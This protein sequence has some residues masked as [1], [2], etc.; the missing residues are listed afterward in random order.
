MIEP[1]SSFENTQ[2]TRALTPFTKEYVFR[3]WAETR[4]SGWEGPSIEK[5]TKID[6]NKFSLVVEKLNV[7]A[8]KNYDVIS[9]VIIEVI[10]NDTKMLSKC[11]HLI[12]YRIPIYFDNLFLS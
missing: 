11:V 12:K 4:S 1:L 8:D 2:D 10:K 6:E 5:E 7:L 3:Y 9:S